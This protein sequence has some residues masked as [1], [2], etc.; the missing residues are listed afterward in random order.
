M[1]GCENWCIQD[2]YI[3]K[4]V[5]LGPCWRGGCEV[6]KSEKKCHYLGQFGVE[7][8]VWCGVNDGIGHGI[9]KMEN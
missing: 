4:W 6:Y 1:Y 2:S 9:H 5:T 3:R 7:G 8:G